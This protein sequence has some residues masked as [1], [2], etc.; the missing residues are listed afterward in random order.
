MRICSV[1]GCMKRHDSHGFCTHHARRFK[2]YGHPLGTN[3]LSN[4]RPRG[5]GELRPD[6]Y[7]RHR[8]GDNRKYEHVLVA[9]KALGRPLPPG[10]IV[11]HHDE[12]R[13]NNSGLN[14]VI[15][16]DSLY[17]KLLHRRM[18]ALDASGH[19]DW[20]KCRFCKKY[21]PPEEI[22]RNAAGFRHLVCSAKYAL[23]A[24]HKNKERHHEVEAA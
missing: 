20:N 4:R 18:L 24:Y 11:H 9:E 5:S 12:T 15:C 19:A 8:L 10:T 13:S 22:G 1:V 6:G 3:P 23:N 16:P 2:T 21:G 7:V 17:H 14:L